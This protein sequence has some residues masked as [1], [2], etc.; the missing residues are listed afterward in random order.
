M[1]TNRAVSFDLAQA[2]ARVDHDALHLHAVGAPA[3]GVVAQARVRQRIYALLDSQPP[4]A[5]DELQRRQ[6]VLEVYID[7]VRAHLEGR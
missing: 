7:L 6:V 1:F 4:V 3:E 2:D 5:S